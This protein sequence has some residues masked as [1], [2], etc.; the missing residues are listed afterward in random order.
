MCRVADV[1]HHTPTTSTRSARACI[2][3]RLGGFVDPSHGV[4]LMGFQHF[5]SLKIVKNVKW[6]LCYVCVSIVGCKAGLQG[7]RHTPLSLL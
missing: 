1:A 4:L 7:P 5:W 3:T 2:T 6:D